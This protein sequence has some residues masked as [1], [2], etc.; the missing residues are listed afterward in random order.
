MALTNEIAIVAQ[1]YLFLGGPYHNIPRVRNADDATLLILLRFQRFLGY[2]RL[3]EH[4]CCLGVEHDVTLAE[5]DD[6]LD[7]LRIGS[8]INTRE[9]RYFI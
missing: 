6:V 2:L 8:V 7:L 5:T 3:E 9:A 4:V 1:S